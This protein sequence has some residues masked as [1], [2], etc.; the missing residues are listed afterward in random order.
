MEKKNLQENSNEQQK[1]SQGIITVNDEN[2]PTREERDERIGKED[3][4][5]RVRSERESVQ[6]TDRSKGS[7]PI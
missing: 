3:D 4:T 6:E 5:E 2:N 7:N 1:S